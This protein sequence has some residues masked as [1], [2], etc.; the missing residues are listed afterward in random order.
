[1]LQDLAHVLRR[2]GFHH[3]QRA[4]VNKQRAIRRK[5]LRKSL[6]LNA[7][8]CASRCVELFEFPNL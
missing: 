5:A 8:Q 7:E 3:P 4:K 6:R 2:V 1:M